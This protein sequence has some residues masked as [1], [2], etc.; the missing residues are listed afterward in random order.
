MYLA[1]LLTHYMEIVQQPLARRTDID[2]ACSTPCKV[3]ADVV[4]DPICF[5]EAS[6]EYGF[7]ANALRRQHRFPS[8][9]V[10]S[11][12]GQLVGAEQR[13]PDRSGKQLIPG[14][15][16]WRCEWEPEAWNCYCCT[17]MK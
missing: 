12:R 3:A 16:G 1:Y 10:T 4:K 17:V 15:P 8:G 6:E 14:I 2:I 7:A 11:L 13:T 9:D 5:G